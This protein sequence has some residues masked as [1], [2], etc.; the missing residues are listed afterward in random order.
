MEGSVVYSPVTQFALAG[1]LFVGIQKDQLSSKV[2]KI[3][4]GQ[5]C[6]VAR[7]N[8]IKRLH[9]GFCVNDD[10]EAQSLSSSR[11]SLFSAVLMG[12]FKGRMGQSP[13]TRLV[14]CVALFLYYAA[15]KLEV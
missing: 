4:V 7:C 6:P 13:Q 11:R 15:I 10:K 2:R 1:R 5:F 12:V 8:C 9:K 3:L 14:D